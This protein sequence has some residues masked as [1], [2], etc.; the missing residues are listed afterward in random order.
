M[1]STDNS[2][3]VSNC[4][5]FQTCNDMNYHDYHFITLGFNCAPALILRDLEL[6]NYSLP[7]DWIITSNNQ[8][9]NCI[10]DDFNKFHKNLHFTLNNHWLMDEYGI[11]YPHDYPVNSNETIVM[12]NS[13]EKHHKLS[14][15]GAASGSRANVLINPKLARCGNRVIASSRHV[16]GWHWVNYDG[17]VGAPHMIFDSSAANEE[18]RKICLAWVMG[19]PHPKGRFGFIEETT[20]VPSFSVTPKGARDACT[21]S[22]GCRRHTERQLHTVVGAYVVEQA[23]SRGRRR[24]TERQSHTVV[25]AYVV[26]NFVICEHKFFYVRNELLYHY[27]AQVEHACRREKA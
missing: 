15:E 12:G 1:I 11:Q 19:L 9:I 20:L 25:G 22:C 13:D 18:E 2:N 27:K 23:L 6:R 8:I 10:E 7:F 4:D 26:V 17:E 16:T 14:N 24:H 21:L 3:D 5:P